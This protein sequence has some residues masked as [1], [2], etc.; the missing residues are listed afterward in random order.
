MYLREF[1]CVI[2][3]AS[4]RVRNCICGNKCTCVFSVPPDLRRTVTKTD[5][6]P[7]LHSNLD[8]IS[9]TVYHLNYQHA[10][11]YVIALHAVSTPIMITMK[12]IKKNINNNKNEQKGYRIAR[13]R[14]IGIKKMENKKSDRIN[15][16]RNDNKSRAKTKCHRE[17]EKNIYIKDKYFL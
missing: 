5:I 9:S 1:V 8:L 10:H 14:T 7:D 2:I 17:I 13:N 11:T 16:I 12:T 15:Y 6:P 3:S 4:H